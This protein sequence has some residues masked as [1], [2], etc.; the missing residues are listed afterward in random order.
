MATVREPAVAG[1]FYPASA[2]LLRAQV[3]KFLDVAV[4]ADLPVPEALIVPHAGYVYSGAVAGTAYASVR[5]RA[6]AIERVVLLGP[7][8]RVPLQG[9]ALPAVEYFATPLGRVPV[10]RDAAVLLSTLP[11]VSSDD[12]VHADEHSLEVQ[13]PFLQLMLTRQFTVVPLAVGHATAV[14]VAG[15]LDAVWG[16]GETLIVVSSDLSHYHDYATACRLDARTVHAI[17]RL[18]WEELRPEAACGCGAIQGLLLAAGRRGLHVRAVDVRN[19]GDTAGP[20]DR[21][22]GYGAFV[23]YGEQEQSA[24]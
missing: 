24:G 1:M 19:S 12:L 10:D 13:L 3:L 4:P 7:A 14:D 23:V 15:V 17:E 21:V 5:P 18:A 9:L 6:A 16:G 11:Q 20:R 8:H 2:G 22:V